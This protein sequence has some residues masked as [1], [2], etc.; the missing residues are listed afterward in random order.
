MF[1]MSSIKRKQFKPKKLFHTMNAPLD[2]SK[3]NN[4]KQNDEILDLSTK[5]A[6]SI[7]KDNGEKLE[8]VKKNK[9]INDK[10][11]S[12]KPLDLR[13]NSK[14]CNNAIDSILNM[15][16]IF[17]ENDYNNIKS[18][19]TKLVRG[20]DEWM[21]NSRNSFIS[22][23]LKCLVCSKSFETLNDLSSHMLETKHFN[24]LSTADNFFN[25]DQ[26]KDKNLN[27]TIVFRKNFKTIYN[28]NKFGN[29][30]NSLSNVLLCLIC[31]KKL[32]GNFIT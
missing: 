12:D 24:K 25:T 13:V 15:K 26:N 5:P 10:T 31:K 23:I 11:E 30:E 6:I 27:K 20:Q 16:Q 8:E 1:S 3:N 17:D 4:N 21:N 7:M 29:N 22:Q 14:K 19:L 32:E 2:L 28:S 18:S 9:E